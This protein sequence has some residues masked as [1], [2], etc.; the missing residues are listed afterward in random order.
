MN[1]L[2][3]NFG[4]RW[5][6]ALPSMRQ[7]R[8]PAINAGLIVGLVLAFG[9]VGSLDF[10]EEQRIEAERHAAAAERATYALAECLNGRA[11]FMAADGQSAT[12]C[13]G[14]REVRN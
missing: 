8:E 11:Q 5:D 10:A 3:R 9:I 12:L 13:L 2:R 4:L 7:M 14:S 1:T 6:G